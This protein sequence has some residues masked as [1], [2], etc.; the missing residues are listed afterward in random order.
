MGAE[1]AV[2]AAPSTDS[3]KMATRRYIDIYLEA[4]NLILAVPLSIVD[5]LTSTF[6]SAGRLLPHQNRA[7]I[8]VENL[9][10]DESRVRRAQKQYWP[11]N[12]LRSTDAPE[13]N[14][15]KNLVARNRII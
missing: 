5:G 3:R 15:P 13:G 10:R 12:F 11:G 9:A 7:A 8:Y 6:R 1:G 4:V 14:A 2:C